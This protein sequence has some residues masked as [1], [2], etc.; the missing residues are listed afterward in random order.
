MSLL[1]ESLAIFK[2]NPAT[3]TFIVLLI[4][5][6]SVGQV[7]SLGSLY[8]ILQSLVTD[9]L[10]DGYRV[11]GFFVSVLNSIGVAPNLQNLLLLFIVLG[12]GY[13]TLNWF[14]DAVQGAYLRNFEIA[15]RRDLLESAV[16]ANWIYA[17]TLRHGE[18]I[19]VV[20]REAGQYKFV[21]KFSLYTFGCF[22]QF[23]A[24]FGY[25]LYLN[26]QV[27][28]LGVLIFAA[29]SMVLIP[30]LKS[31]NRLGRQSTDIANNMSN[32]LVAALH[33]L[34]TVKALSLE[35]SLVRTLQPSFEFSSSNYFRQNLLSSGQ[36]AITEV[37]AFTAISSMLF[38]GL[39]TLRI[40]KAELFIILLLLFRALPQVRSAID[41]YHRAYGYLPSMEIVRRH[42]ARAS[43]ASNQHY[44]MPVSGDWKQIEFQKVS[45]AYE[46]G[47]QIINDLSFGL[48]RGEFWAVVGPTGSGKTTLL[49]IL[50]GL[51]QPRKGAVKIDGVPLNDIDL[52]S[53]HVQ[54][55]YLGQ[56]AYVFA[57]TLRDNLV[58]GSEREFKD[59]EL[60]SALQIVKLDGM[61]T[62]DVEVLD[63]DVGEN[64]CNLSG[65]EKQRLALARLFLRH[66][67]LM[68]L[69]EP[70]TGLDASTEREI[71]NSI[72]TYFQ[73]TTLIMV[74]HREE[75]THNADRI[76]RFT[77][78]GVTVES[79]IKTD[80]PGAS[81]H[82]SFARRGMS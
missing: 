10:S 35:K 61:A 45:F 74:T 12:I 66:A 22:L 18:F 30:L 60:L 15:I 57:G 41:N 50:L 9:E 7:V 71:F 16:G 48:H 24:L 76:I 75:L 82:P 52:V 63:I 11:S 5:A 34:K 4:T 27:T 23:A 49:D 67:P 29:G 3:S 69:D 42:M 26:W 2:R 62:H 65:G 8:P 28:V 80:H 70:T 13:S 21:V 72:S 39:T 77:P 20:T 44:G 59:S 19:N 1:R 33:S 58:W 79:G 47:G 36:W 31:A 32:R 46:D 81:R 40:S 43:S 37:I 78:E 55:S 51:L 6:A 56:E 25:A 17:R 53:W 38:I 68:I 54:V 14:A 64:G 73:D